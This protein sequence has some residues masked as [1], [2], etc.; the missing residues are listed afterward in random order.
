[1]DIVE[2]QTLYNNQAFPDVPTD[3]AFYE[4]HANW[5]LLGKAFA[6]KIKKPVHFSFMDFSTLEKRKYFCEQEVQLNQRMEPEV[7]LEVLPVQKKGEQVWIGDGAGQIIDYAVK[8]K[9]LDQDRQMHLLLQQSAVKPQHIAQIAEKLANFH[10]SAKI[11][12][13][14]PQWS[15]L[16]EDF[17]DLA[18]VKPALNEWFGHETANFIDLLILETKNF[19]STHQ[20]V[21][22]DRF[23][24]GFWRDGHGD[25]HTGNIFLTEPPVI[26]DCIEF[27]AHFRKLDILDEIA[28]LCMDLDFFDRRA[29][30]ELLLQAYH[31]AM[32]LELRPTDRSLFYY[33]KSYRAN[34]RL[35]VTAL[36]YLQT[37]PPPSKL[38]EMKRYIELL[39]R[40]LP[41]YCQPTDK[42]HQQG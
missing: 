1:M 8:M 17:A 23:N 36:G 3:K 15:Q 19:L 34:V 13:D 30:A 31:E 21:L 27:N 33:Y 40:Y 10:Q 6:F 28:F 11:L 41:F 42:T 29:Y 4:T 35:K 14:A 2:I 25:L 18:Q 24:H 20:H 12:N 38:T 9:R 22:T 7:Y 32:K 39:K 5:I 37:P 16:F 26:F